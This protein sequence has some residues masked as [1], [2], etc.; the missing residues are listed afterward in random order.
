VV[1]SWG[2]NI[3]ALVKYDRTA[4]PVPTNNGRKWIWQGRRAF[5]TPTLGRQGI[6]GR[7]PAV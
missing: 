3:L 7:S 4:T 1:N 6:A 2:A 5:K